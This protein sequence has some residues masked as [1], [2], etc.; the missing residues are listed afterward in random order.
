MSWKVK[1]AL[2]LAALLAAGVWYAEAADVGQKSVLSGK[3]L[4][5]AA[6]GTAV[7]EGDVLVTVE[8]LAGAVP[9]VKATANGVVKEVK[10]HEGDMVNN[11]TVAVVLETQ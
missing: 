7:K 4:S 2:A 1:T 9:A 11:Q 10:V 6:V 5:V 3:V 8:T